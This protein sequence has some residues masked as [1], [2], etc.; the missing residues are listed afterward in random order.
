MLPTETKPHKQG[1]EC[2]YSRF[3][4]P[5]RIL[6]PTS[7]HYVVVTHRDI[8]NYSLSKQGKKTMSELGMSEQ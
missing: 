7:S 2:P 4:S 3:P 8:R 5:S 6:Q 1:C